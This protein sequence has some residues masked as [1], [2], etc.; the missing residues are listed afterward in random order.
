MFWKCVNILE[1]IDLQ[2]IAATSDGASPNRKF[3]R[4]HKTFDDQPGRSVVYHAQ[5]LCSKDKRYIYFFADVPHLI[6]T[7]R[8]CIS[9]SNAGSH[10]RY[11]WNDGFYILWTHIRRMFYNDLNCGLKL[12]PKL[13]SDH[14]NLTPYSIMRVRLAAQVLSETVGSILNSFAS[15]DMQGTAKLCLMVDKFFECLNVRNTTE[16]KLKRKPFLKPYHSVDDERF[17]WLD[18]FLKYFEQW[19][20]SIEN[21]SGN[22]TQLE[23]RKMFISW[24]SYEGVQITVYSFTE[25]CKFLL[26]HGVKYVLSE[27][28]CQDDL[29]NYFG[30]QRAIG[31]RRDNPSARDV[32]YNHNIIKSHFSVRPI[33]GSNVESHVNKFNNIDNVPLPK[34]TQEY[35]KLIC[36]NTCGRDIRTVKT[37]IFIATIFLIHY[38]FGLSCA[39]II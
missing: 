21:R 18:S 8:N 35:E 32:G 5:N 25:L 38:L 19:K 29:E 3:F 27:R 23:K 10:S 17:E 26:Q 36:Q 22:F 16:H 1:N 15:P 2:V 28:F 9:N 37:A 39:S 12:M 33:S 20:E 30:Q 31:R 6:K 34:K 4:M 24:Q 11:M 14:I 13:T 7:F